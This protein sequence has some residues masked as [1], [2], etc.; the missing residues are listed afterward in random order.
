M[1]THHIKSQ[2]LTSNQ[3]YIAQ[4]VSS[5]TEPLGITD[6]KELEEITNDVI[7]RLEGILPGMERLIPATAKQT[8]SDDQIRA[9]VR[10]IIDKKTKT[11]KQQPEPKAAPKIEFTENAF[12]VLEK[13][14]LKK[15]N[16]GRIIE[17]PED[18]FHRVA[19]HIA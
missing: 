13:R 4:I 12:V 7:R 19:N 8:L 3:T 9:V 1:T 2:A 10:E 5:Y 16:L 18:M 14:Y 6:R 11:V 15:D 17:S